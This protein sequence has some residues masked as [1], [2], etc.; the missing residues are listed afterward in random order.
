MVNKCHGYLKKV[1]RVLHYSVPYNHI[2]FKER[3]PVEYYL[4][5]S[6]A[7]E[8]VDVFMT[9]GAIQ[10]YVPAALI[11]VVLRDSRAKPKS[12]ILSVLK[13][14]SS[15]LSIDSRISTKKVMNALFTECLKYN[16]INNLNNLLSWAII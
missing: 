14:K 15:S 2:D 7:L 6:L 8:K 12:V 9:S 4:Q 13:R 16:Y 3:T 10:A 11:R 1:N 5:T